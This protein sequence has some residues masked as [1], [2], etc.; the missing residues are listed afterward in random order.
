MDHHT[1]KVSKYVAQWKADKDRLFNILINI[2][3]FKI[4]LLNYLDWT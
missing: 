3:L 2:D 4:I 1:I